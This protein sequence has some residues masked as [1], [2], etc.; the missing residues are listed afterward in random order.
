[1]AARVAAREKAAAATPGGFDRNIRDGR[2]Q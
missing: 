2:G 1:M